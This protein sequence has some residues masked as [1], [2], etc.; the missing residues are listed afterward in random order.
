MFEVS[1][2][3]FFFFAFLNWDVQQCLT[4]VL[5]ISNENLKVL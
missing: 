5:S 2:F 3:F 1:G 4:V